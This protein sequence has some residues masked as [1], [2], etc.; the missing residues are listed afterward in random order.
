MKM[1]NFFGY[2]GLILAV[3]SVLVFSGCPNDNGG[4]DSVDGRLVASWTNDP[5]NK[6]AADGDLGN[7]SGL[8]KKFEIKNDSTFEA[9]INVIF[10]TLLQETLDQASQGENWQLGEI[11]L[12]DL[13]TADDQTLGAVNDVAQ[14]VTGQ[15]QG[16]EFDNLVWTVTGTLEKGENDIYKMMD[17]NATGGDLSAVEGV[18]NKLKGLTP[19]VVKPMSD[20]AV[21]LKIESD[22]TFTF[23]SAA[24][25]VV[26]AVNEYFGGTYT[27]VVVTPPAAQ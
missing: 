22:G 15:F 12:A 16:I 11:K 3:V 18:D 14:G 5:N 9:K 4:D 7:L 13:A 26:P 25:P 23:S 24:N 2:A 20:Q 8:I 10:L 17:L 19:S 27:K 6:Y 21:Q 1:K